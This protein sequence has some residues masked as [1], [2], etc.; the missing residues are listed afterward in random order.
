MPCMHSRTNRC[1]R[2][3]CARAWLISLALAATTLTGCLTGVREYVQNGFK[4]GP[5]YCTPPAPITDHWID[6]QDRRVQEGSDIRHDWW[7][8]FNDPKL[9]Q[10]IQSAYQQNISLREAGAR[11]HEAQALRAVSVGNLFPQDQT[12]YGA[13]SR[14]ML[15]LGT[16]VQAGGGA[17]FP[18]IQRNFSVWNLGTQ[19]NWELDFW[20]KYRRAIEASDAQLEASVANFDDVLTLLVSD[21]ART[22]V[23]IRTIEQRI[24]YAQ[25]NVRS[26]SGSLE[27]ART[28]L[29]GGAASKLDVAQAA[30]NLGQ[31][32]STIPDLLR[33]LR[34]AEN[35]M[36]V[37]LGISPQDI[38]AMIGEPRGIPRAP[39]EVVL[40]VPADLL[41]RRPDIRRAER[42]VAVQSARIGIAESELYPAFSITGNI[43]VRANDF[44]TLF[45]PES[46]GGNVGPQFNW[47]ILNYGRIRNTVAAEDARFMQEV[48]QY[49]N[50]VLN[51]HREAEDA[52]VGFL[53][54]QEQAFS[55]GQAAQAAEES[56]DLIQELYRGGNADF[57]RVFVA[58]LVLAQQQDELALAEGSIATNLVEVYRALGGGW[59]LRLHHEAM[60]HGGEWVMPPTGTTAPLPAPVTPEP[61]LQRPGIQGPAIQGPGLPSPARPGPALPGQGIQSPTVPGP[62]APTSV[63]PAPAEPTPAAPRPAAPA[64]VNPQATRHPAIF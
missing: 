10:L 48:A 30:T 46:V 3:F 15:S 61:G 56:R 52:I 23:E 16:G 64:S 19:L 33:Q 34:Q 28:K 38:R 31:T 26:Q 44:D 7:M 25:S 57:G 17:G 47:N 58:E 9:D 1:R 6:Y 21:V 40:G 4:V 35:R 8:V 18:G 11:I 62:A 13:Y 59:Q 20:G 37:L 14:Q 24:V 54:A 36:C 53:R 27:L 5:N 2:S 45:R 49:Q 39:A 51:A 41:R 50:A 32:E 43:F 60:H 55:L 22:Y 29:A 12:A 63:T 42:E